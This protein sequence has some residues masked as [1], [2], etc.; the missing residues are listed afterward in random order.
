MNGGRRT[1]P[2]SL[3]LGF[4]VEMRGSEDDTNHMRLT[5]RSIRAVLFDA[6]GVLYH[7]PRANARLATVLARRGLSL[8]PPGELRARLAAERLSAYSGRLSLR[9]FNLATL[10]ACGIPEGAFAED[11][12]A[13]MA[14]DAADIEVFPGVPETLARL[15][16]AGLDLGIVTDTMHPTSAKL[17]WMAARGVPPE[18]FGAVAN[19]V[20]VRAPKPS[21]DIYFAALERLGA[22]PEHA[23]F[24]G[25]ATDEIEG[26]AAIGCATIA[27]RPDDPGVR[28]DAR[29]DDFRRLAELLVGGG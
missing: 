10:R 26:A 28:A 4:V 25:H 18:T 7:R 27:F 11:A 9:D 12:L 20:E 13:A 5:S 29:T 24:V 14:E 8:V 19:S 22:A 6:Y 23:A 17:A 21:P 2:L 15:R 3:A 16:G 1:G